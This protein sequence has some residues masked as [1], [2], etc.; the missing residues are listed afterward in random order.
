MFHITYC[1]PENEIVSISTIYIPD[2]RGKIKRQWTRVECVNP[3]LEV[4]IWREIQ[5]YK[6]R[7]EFGQ[8]RFEQSLE[9]GVEISH[10]CMIQTKESMQQ[11]TV[12]EIGETDEGIWNFKIEQERR[13]QERHALKILKWPLKYK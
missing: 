9:T 5:R 8:L 10:L 11:R 6:V 12:E 3:F 4:Q 7:M 13:S 2:S 1:N